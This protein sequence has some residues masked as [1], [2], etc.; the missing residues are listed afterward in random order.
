MHRHVIG[1]TG[2]G[3]TASILWPSVLQ[4][5]LDGKGILVMAAKG[6]D[7]NI[8]VVKAIAQLAGRADQLRIF[9]LPAWNQPQLPSGRYNMVY[10][11][12][13]KDGDRGGDPAA[14][15]ERGFSILQLGDTEDY[16]TQAEIMLVTL[17]KLLHGRA[18]DHVAGWPCV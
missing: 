15:A 17:G 13:P 10:V 9:A 7:E 6:S 11:R 8:R 12:P 14:T 5:A 3:N 1:K 18:S 4:D 2:S 16:T